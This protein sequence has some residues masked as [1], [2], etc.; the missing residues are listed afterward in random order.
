VFAVGDCNWNRE[1]KGRLKIFCIT[2]L[3]AM[4][5]SSSEQQA[6]FISSEQ[7]GANMCYFFN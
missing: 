2:I 7:L 6:V 3:Q 1:K 4:A 5:P